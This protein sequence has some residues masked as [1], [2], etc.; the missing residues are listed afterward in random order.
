MLIDHIKRNIDVSKTHNDPGR[1]YVQFVISST[2]EIQDI[3]VRAE[4]A[5]QI[6]E[7]KRVL[8]GLKIKKPATL[9]GE[10]V[11]IIH[12]VPVV[13]QTQIYNSHEDYLKT[14]IKEVQRVLNEEKP[15]NAKN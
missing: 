9:D 13:F 6:K 11:A 2:G 1:A 5:N 8:S 4:S 7:A 15:K 14:Q 12:S 3:K 10:N